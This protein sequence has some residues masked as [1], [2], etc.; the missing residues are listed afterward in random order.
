MLCIHTDKCNFHNNFERAGCF[1][2]TISG[3]TTFRRREG[4][5]KQQ[6]AIHFYSENWYVLKYLLPTYRFSTGKTL[7]FLTN[8]KVLIFYLYIQKY[9]PLFSAE[10]SKMEKKKTTVNRQRERF[11]KKKKR[12]FK[13]FPLEFKINNSLRLLHCCTK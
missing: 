10:V 13:N 1:H 6:N 12:A 2:K 5:Q 11:R 7:Y 8:S 4:F 3:R 9:S